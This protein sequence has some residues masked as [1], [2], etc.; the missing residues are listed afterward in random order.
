MI[1]LIPLV[2]DTI[3]AIKLQITHYNDNQ[4]LK[5]NLKKKKQFIY[6]NYF[7]LNFFYCAILPMPLP[8]NNWP[9]SFSLQ[10]NQFL[11]H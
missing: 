7:R 10:Q 11:Y 8:K 3:L 9:V 5:N 2:Y 6:T 4:C 1:F